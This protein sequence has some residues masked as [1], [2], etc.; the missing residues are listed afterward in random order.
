MRNINL[1]KTEDISLIQII[2]NLDNNHY[3]K[4][5]IKNDIIL[6]TNF[7]EW[8]IDKFLFEIN[9][10]GMIFSEIF[11]GKAIKTLDSSLDNFMIN[12]TILEKNITNSDEQIKHIERFPFKKG[13]LINKEEFENSFNLYFNDYFMEFCE[14]SI[15]L[16]FSSYVGGYFYFNEPSVV[17]M[18]CELKDDYW[19]FCWLPYI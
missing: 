17:V 9:M 5:K 11:I 4:I 1:Y 12:A 6:N 13:N 15:K 18:G 10:V 2:H 8:N 16:D 7:N 19:Y 14:S 3:I